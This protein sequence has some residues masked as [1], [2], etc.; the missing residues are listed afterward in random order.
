M[1]SVRLFAAGST[2][3][4]TLTWSQTALVMGIV[5]VALLLIGVIVIWAR[6]KD[7]GQSVVRSWIALA[8]V[9]GLILFCAVTFAIND[10][11][12]RSTVFGGLTTS[13]GAAIAFYFS[14][15]TSDQAR[16]DILKA[17]GHPVD[18]GD[19]G[20]GAGGAGASDPG[21]GDPGAGDA[22]AGGAAAA[23]NRKPPG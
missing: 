9:A 3:P 15:K 22:E 5:A 6:S 10:S 13:V 21:A 11:N 23:R 18:G 17:M 16:Q 1:H 20:A 4:S 14:S 8:L 12:L 2:P 7:A 19:G